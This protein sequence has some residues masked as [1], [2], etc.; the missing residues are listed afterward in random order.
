METKDV[1]EYYGPL[2]APQIIK[3]RNELKDIIIVPFF[4][5][6]AKGIGYNLSPSELIYSLRRRG[7]VPICHDSS[8]SYIKIR[9]HDTVL[10]LSYEYLQVNNNI[11]GTFHSRV[12]CSAK[13]MGSV[14]TTLDPGWKGMLLFSINNPTKKSVRL[15][16]FE[17]SDGQIE[18]SS[19]LTLV[20]S[21]IHTHD[22]S[23]LLTFH[24]DNPPMRAD[25]WDE[26]IDPPHRIRKNKEYQRFKAI[27]RRVIEFQPVESDTIRRIDKLIDLLMDLK[28]AFG[29]DN[30]LN[31]AKKILIH[32]QRMV[33]EEDGRL[34]E[35]INQVETAIK[36]EQ[37]QEAVIELIDSVYRECQ[38]IRMCDEVDQMHKFIHE[39]IE[40]VW[41]KGW[42]SRVFFRWVY[43]NLGAILSS[44]ILL[45]I[46]LVFYFI[47]EI[48]LVEI[49]SGIAISTI[50]TILSII[51]NFIHNRK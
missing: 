35:K 12:R 29:V 17:K 2:T 43:P 32:I 49:V 24:L 28:C 26:L 11:C 20:P 38:Y 40:A 46:L 47:P 39:N 15:D 33:S 23:D 1:N 3:C 48:N 8:G 10:I 21:R 27:I 7:L 37:D 19:L 45:F 16:I 25:I 5:K 9:P 4:D 31:E 30:R 42:F 6:K 50:P 36:D 18:N 14:S 13:G 34:K 22:G 51:F 44:L 41:K